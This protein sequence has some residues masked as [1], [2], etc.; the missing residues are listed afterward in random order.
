LL[1]ARPRVKLVLMVKSLAKIVSLQTP[2]RH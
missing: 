2:K 1:G